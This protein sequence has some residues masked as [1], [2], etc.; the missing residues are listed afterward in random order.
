MAK[1]SASQAS[2]T[3]TRHAMNDIAKALVTVFKKYTRTDR[4]KAWDKITS[5]QGL[6]EMKK[7]LQDP[8][9]P[10]NMFAQISLKEN[11]FEQFLCKLNEEEEFTMAIVECPK[12]NGV[13][14]LGDHNKHGEWFWFKGSAKCQECNETFSAIDMPRIGNFKVKPAKLF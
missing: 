3:N 4:N 10:I 1:E 12:C 2:Q 6:R 7:L 14:T 8:N 13:A 5:E 11:T 9:R